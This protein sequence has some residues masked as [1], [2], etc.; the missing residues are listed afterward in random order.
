MSYSLEKDDGMGGVFI[1]VTGLSAD[2]LA[3]TQ[4]ISHGIS[5]GVTY[6]F[7]YRARN[8]YGWSPYSDISFLL[9]A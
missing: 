5:K 2:N 3:T 6:R 1:P 7:R 9:A 4:L 8:K